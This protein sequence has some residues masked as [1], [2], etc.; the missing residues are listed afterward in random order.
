MTVLYFKNELVI[1]NVKLLLI[2]KIR[3][4]WKKCSNPMKML[5]RR[6][7]LYVGASFAIRIPPIQ[8]I[9]RVI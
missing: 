1:G 7:P 2:A 8:I 4:A 3:A 9:T 6:N 5:N